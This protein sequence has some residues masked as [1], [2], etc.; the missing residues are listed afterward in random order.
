MIKKQW[1]ILIYLIT[2]RAKILK[3]IALYYMCQGQTESIQMASV[4]NH[5]F[6]L[7]MLWLYC[8]LNRK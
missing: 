3:E 7:S 6:D 2:S 8:M 4:L 1:L 5:V